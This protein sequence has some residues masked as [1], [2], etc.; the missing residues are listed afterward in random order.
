MRTEV[1]YR[2]SAVGKDGAG[3]TLTPCRIIPPDTLTPAVRGF[4]F[5]SV[6]G[7]SQDYRPDPRGHQQPHPSA[8]PA[9]A[10]RRSVQRPPIE[11]ADIKALAERDN[12]PVDQDI[13][14]QL[15]N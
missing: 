12:Y 2:L 10:T 14:N 15:E 8:S 5:E 3:Y 1:G 13:L 11:L 9:R 7:S 6:Y 4:G